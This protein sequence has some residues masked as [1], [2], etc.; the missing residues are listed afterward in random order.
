MERIFEYV[1]DAHFDNARLDTFLRTHYRMSGS[2][3]KELKRESDGLVVNGVQARTTDILHDGDKIRLCL[4]ETASE[5][6]APVK[7]EFGIEYEDED[8]MIVNK[9]P[10][11]PTHIS[12]GN[13]DNTLSNA[14][15]YYFREQ[16]EEYVF[17]A[18]NRLDKDTSGLMCIAKN[19]YVHARLCDDFKGKSVKR[20]YTA[21]VCG[22]TKAEDTINAPIGRCEESVIK[23]QV[24]ADGQTAV[25]HYRTI[26]QTKGYSLI[27]LELETGRT[28]QIRVH[29]AY[30]GFPL[31]G[32]WL[33]GEDNKALFARQA[34]HS[35]SL[36]L[37][38]PVKN[39]EITVKSDLPADMR[40]FFEKFFNRY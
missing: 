31:L 4:R 1:V 2:L 28:H 36:S 7:L 20:R 15:M 40:D 5:N 33:Y 22:E 9:P 6:I 11:M 21:I 19:K 13:Y 35:S 10:H 29:M 17:R 26:A 18:V 37:V 25:T 32:D 14:L 39:T 16:G 34:L 8:L 27:E 3:I 23:R 30:A 38:H 12:A 24:S